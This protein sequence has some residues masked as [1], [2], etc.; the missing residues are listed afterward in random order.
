MTAESTY[1]WRR[2]LMWGLM[3]IALGTV[4]LLDRMDIIE[5]RT[6][7]HY[8]P[9]V[10]VVFGINKMIGYPTARHFISGLWTVFMG[11]WL[12]ANFEHL[13]GLNFSNSWPFVIIA[14]GVSIVL[15][16]VVEKRFASNE[17]NRH[18]K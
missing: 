6:F 14:A 2:Q 12:F 3:L 8:V 16:P 10:M 1:E 4:F 15:R 13:F 17:G 11:L 5:A 18:E 7:W 9:L